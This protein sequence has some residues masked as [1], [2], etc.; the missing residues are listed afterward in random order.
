M[1]NNTLIAGSKNCA[2]A[3]LLFWCP[4]TCCLNEIHCYCNQHN[5][6]GLMNLQEL[7]THDVGMVR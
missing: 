2:G 5:S 7:V 1:K 6:A 3:K 4:C